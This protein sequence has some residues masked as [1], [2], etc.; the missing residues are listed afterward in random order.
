MVHFSMKSLNCADMASGSLNGGRPFLAIKNSAWRDT[1]REH[2]RTSANAKE[3]KKEKEK[4]D[5][6]KLIE[7]SEVKKNEAGGEVP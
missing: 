7:R 4:H 5:K 6:H 2:Q 1:K 3:E